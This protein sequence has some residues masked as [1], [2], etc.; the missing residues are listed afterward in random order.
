MSPSGL[1]VPS[2]PSN[3]KAPEAPTTL[4]AG[5]VRDFKAA[6]EAMDIAGLIGILD[7]DAIAITDG[8][9]SVRAA[10]H[11][12]HGGE[13]VARAYVEI[14]ARAPNIT[15]LERTVNGQPGLIVQ[16]E[17]VTVTVI[18]FDVAGERIKSIWATR[19]PEKLWLWSTG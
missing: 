7:P 14:A 2:S 17:G 10:L 12:I 13:Q 5:I 1:I 4:Q 11:P 16:Q 9:G 8:G 6:W 18:A 3:V 19:N 15:V